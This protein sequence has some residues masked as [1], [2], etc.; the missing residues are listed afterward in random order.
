MANPADSEYTIPKT[1]NPYGN[2]GQTLHDPWTVDYVQ[3]LAEYAPVFPMTSC[4]MSKSKEFHQTDDALNWTDRQQWLPVQQQAAALNEGALSGVAASGTA[5]QDQEIQ[6][7]VAPIVINKSYNTVIKIDAQQ[8]AD[9]KAYERAIKAYMNRLS[10]QIEE[11]IHKEI[12][13]K[14]TMT[15]TSTGKMSITDLEKIQYRFNQ[16]GLYGKTMIAFYAPC[17]YSSLIDVLSRKEY[18]SSR[19]T[20]AIE[21][22]RVPNLLANMESFEQ[23]SGVMLNQFDIDTTL[24]TSQSNNSSLNTTPQLYPDLNVLNNPDI[25]GYISKHHTNGNPWQQFPSTFRDPGDV[26][27]G[28]RDNRFAK[29]SFTYKGAMLKYG[30]GGVLAGDKPLVVPAGS[31]FSVGSSAKAVDGFTKQPSGQDMQFTM[32]E[33]F[34]PDSNQANANGVSN[35]QWISVSPSPISDEVVPSGKGLVGVGLP[36]AYQNYAGSPDASASTSGSGVTFLNT[37]SQTPSYFLTPESV[38]VVSAEQE[39]QGS[40]GWEI[41]VGYT[42]SGFPVTIMKQAN[43]DSMQYRIKLLCNFGVSMLNPQEGL[44]FLSEQKASSVSNSVSEE[45]ED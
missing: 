35:V 11:C 37:K 39:M 7:L 36:S 38:A 42:P 18:D 45:S 13:S 27:S 17:D 25:S 32:T 2:V 29:V 3:T 8:I 21:G 30:S 6:Q 19:T 31:R 40:A 10:W 43:A 20:N 14:A 9:T 41:S 23:G 22:Y 1:R 34:Q 44:V 16:N 12:Q 15:S 28:F 5:A 4:F 33:D 24:F 26:N